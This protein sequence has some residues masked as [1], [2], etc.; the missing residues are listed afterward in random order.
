MFQK[1]SLR[2]EDILQSLYSSINMEMTSNFQRIF[3]TPTEDDLSIRELTSK[4]GLTAKDYFQQAYENNEFSSDYTFGFDMYNISN[5]DANSSVT[6]VSASMASCVNTKS[7]RSSTSYNCTFMIPYAVMNNHITTYKGAKE[8]DRLQV[9]KFF[10]K[11][12][13][14]DKVLQI[15]LNQ[16]VISLQTPTILCNTNSFNFKKPKALIEPRVI[17]SKPTKNKYD[18]DE[19]D[20]SNNCKYRGVRR[21]KQITLPTTSSSGNKK[22]P[23]NARSH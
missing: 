18:S 8:Q 1:R 12:E 7:R 6:A 9:V 14:Y 22:T 23:L 20:T 11:T 3:G 4:Q 17:I 2:Q 16:K 19:D 5:I 13:V 21:V 15:W 10:W